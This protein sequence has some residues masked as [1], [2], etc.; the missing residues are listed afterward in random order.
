MVLKCLKHQSYINDNELKYSTVYF[1]SLTKTAI[2][3]RYQLNE[4]FEGILNLLDIQINES[5]GWTIEQIVGLYI[6]ISNYEPLSGS[7]YIPLPKVLNNSMKGL[8]NLKNKDH[9]C[10]IWCHV[11]ILN[12]QNKNTERINKQDKRTAANLNYSDIDFPLDINDYELIDN[13][14]K[15][16]INVFGYENKFILYTFQKNL[17]LKHL[18]CY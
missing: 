13:R 12:P 10:F 3:Q 17:T 15:M 9:K 11:R 6:D 14:F 18:I 5:S 7:S 16:N 4:S 1:N 2:N 8:I